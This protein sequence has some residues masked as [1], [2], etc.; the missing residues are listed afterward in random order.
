MRGRGKRNHQIER[1]GD[2]YNGREKISGSNNRL[3]LA[4]S[5]R[6]TGRKRF[7]LAL[8]GSLRCHFNVILVSKLTAC[9]TI[10]CFRS[11]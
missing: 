4:R 5:W 3:P 6:S 8:Q 1:R 7:H 9:R 11:I 10:D 2:I